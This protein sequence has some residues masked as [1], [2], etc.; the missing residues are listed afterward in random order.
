MRESRDGSVKICV[1]F[2]W[3]AGDGLYQ[4]GAMVIIRRQLQGEQYIRALRI[5]GGSVRPRR[6]PGA[7]SMSYHFF[8]PR[9]A[10]AKSAA[11]VT[12]RAIGNDHLRAGDGYRVTDKSHLLQHLHRPRSDGDEHVCLQLMRS[13]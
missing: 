7:L 3:C 6:I 8:S 4:I 10:A 2:L 5:D 12:V 11:K 13:Q 1:A 9:A